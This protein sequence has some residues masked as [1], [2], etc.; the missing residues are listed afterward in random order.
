MSPDLINGLFEI[1]SGLFVLN[2][3]RVILKDKQVAGVSI[4]SVLFFVVWGMWNLYYYPHLGQNISFYGGIFICFAN[5][6]WVS[7]L[8]KYKLLQNQLKLDE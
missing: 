6:V 8:I 4:I 1:F 2:H 5:I 7:L 3:C